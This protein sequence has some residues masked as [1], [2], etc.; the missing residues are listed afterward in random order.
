MVLLE[1]ISSEAVLVGTDVLDNNNV[2]VA[3]VTPRSEQVSTAW[4]M[5]RYLIKE[6]VGL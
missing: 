3:V 1:D 5:Y 6:L 2:G 4:N